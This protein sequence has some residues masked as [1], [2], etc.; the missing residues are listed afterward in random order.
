MSWEQEV[1][2]VVQV[3]QAVKVVEL[4][5]TVVQGM[6]QVEE[7][8]ELGQPVTRYEMWERVLVLEPRWLLERGWVISQQQVRALARVQPARECECRLPGAQVLLPARQVL[9]LLRE[10]QARKKQRAR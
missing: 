6:E 9:V 4:L 2:P 1:R 5:V 8:Q 10:A 3:A 7:Q